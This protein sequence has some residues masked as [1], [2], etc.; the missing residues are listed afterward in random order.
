[1]SEDSLTL[2]RSIGSVELQLKAQFL[3]QDLLVII[4]GGEAHAGAAAVGG[5]LTR[6]YASVITVPGHRDDVVA[7]E[8][9]LRLSSA[10][11]RTCI[12]LVGI[13]INNASKEQIGNVVR[14]SL[15]LV[16]ELI[17]ALK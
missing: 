8:A 14:A 3:G 9:A 15:E 2:A 1:L 13:H 11:Q 5:F 4:S 16:S 7:K 12:V 10:L 17:E 6:P